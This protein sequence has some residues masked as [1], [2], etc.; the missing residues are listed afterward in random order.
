MTEIEKK[1]YYEYLKKEY[2]KAIDTA[3]K[4]HCDIYFDTI[5]SMHL[6]ELSEYFKKENKN[7]TKST[8]RKAKKKI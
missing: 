4:Y 6:A 1:E 2:Q 3:K 5:E 7:D 8:K